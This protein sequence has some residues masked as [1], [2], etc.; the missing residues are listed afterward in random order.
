VAIANG[1]SDT[2]SAGGIARFRLGAPDSEMDFAGG[3]ARFDL[4]AAT[5]SK[6]S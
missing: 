1:R 4:A 2:Q 6:G 5:K 3:I